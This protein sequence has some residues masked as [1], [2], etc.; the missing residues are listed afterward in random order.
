MSFTQNNLSINTSQITIIQK[1]F[2]LVENVK[3]KIHQLKDEFDI[4]CNRIKHKEYEGLSIK[5]VDISG[6]IDGVIRD[7]E[8]SIS[9]ANHQYQYDEKNSIEFENYF[10]MLKFISAIIEKCLEVF[11]QENSSKY[12]NLVK[13]FQ[14]LAH[15]ISDKYLYGYNNK[16][17]LDEYFWYRYSLYNYLKKINILEKFYLPEFG[18]RYNNLIRNVINIANEYDKYQ[19][20]DIQNLE[21]SPN[22]IN[23]LLVN[24]ALGEILFNKN[25][26]K[27]YFEVLRNRD[28]RNYLS[29]F[30]NDNQQAYA[31][32]MYI[33]IERLDNLCDNRSNIISK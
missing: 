27:F 6:M 12:D 19:K 10:G 1:N 18:Y 7:D 13:A 20:D 3:S 24:C 17:H 9:N 16:C 14:E 2:I 28:C 11:N 26:N 4:I 30:F 31:F 23:N 5:F 33:E 15:K 21:S 25:T 29:Y 32:M 8:L 22:H